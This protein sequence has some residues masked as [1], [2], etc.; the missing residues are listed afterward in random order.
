MVAFC[1]YYK[2]NLEIRLIF[3]LWN[4]SFVVILNN[5]PVY[6][7]CMY[8]GK[9]S[10]LIAAAV[11]NLRRKTFFF[12]LFGEE[13]KDTLFRIKHTALLRHSPSLKIVVRLTLFY[14][15][16]WRTLVS[17]SIYSCTVYD[18]DTIAEQQH[19]PLK[20]RKCVLTDTLTSVSRLLSLSFFLSFI[21]THFTHKYICTV[22]IYC[23]QRPLFVSIVM[24]V[25]MEGDSFKMLAH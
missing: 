22:Y 1:E 17:F 5:D 4:I 8:A 25:S 3:Y 18:M 21:H 12:C 14:R 13:K 23:T 2:I 11:N 20:Q 15:L 7:I 24:V 10:Y 19:T 16:T 9:R 6:H